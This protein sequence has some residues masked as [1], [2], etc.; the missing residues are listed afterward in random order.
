MKYPHSRIINYQRNINGINMMNIGYN[1]LKLIC[2]NKITY[3]SNNI[4]S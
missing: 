1:Y 2:E 4:E 3:M